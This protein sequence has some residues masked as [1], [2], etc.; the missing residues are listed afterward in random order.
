L[1]QL[2]F[3]Q[4]RDKDAQQFLK[5]RDYE[6]IRLTFDKMTTKLNM[7]QFY[8]KSFSLKSQN[9]RKYTQAFY[10]EILI[11]YA[12][13]PRVAQNYRERFLST[14]EEI[15][16][17]LEMYCKNDYVS[18]FLKINF[19][20]ISHKQFVEL[21]CICLK[22]DSFKIAMQ[23]Y[24]RFLTNFDITP[25]IME[26]IILSLRD[27]CKFHEM[28]LFLI[29]EHFDLLSIEQMNQLV[30][31][32]MEILHR[33]E[34]KLNPMLSQYNTIKYSLLIYRISWKI[35]QKKIYSLITK[36]SLLNKYIYTGLAAYLERQQHI[37][38]LYQFMREPIFHM[39]ERKDSLDIMLEMN[40]ES[41]LKHPV[42]VE[43][44]NL[45]YEGKYSVDS[46]AL[47]LS[48]TFQCFFLMETADLKSINQRILTNISTF[49]ESGGGK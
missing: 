23:I 44:L 6:I 21:F 42:I 28:K 33:K 16:L 9:Y 10:E 32:Y 15:Y 20:E 22:S 27:S 11:D 1:R 35:E 3:I 2:R 5:Q 26:I 39:T 41:L 19:E 30:D 38:Q 8:K 40:M 4:L 47:N 49:G 17:V 48:Q 14:A 24:L 45:V 31:I 29:H 37:S 25:K 18:H 12:I 43:V 7:N 13:E 36:C 46:S 34:L